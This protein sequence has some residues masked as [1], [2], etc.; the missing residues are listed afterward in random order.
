MRT[1][2]PS[3]SLANSASEKSPRFVVGII[4]DTDSLYFTSH[5]DIANVPGVVTHRVLTVKDARS[6]KI[7][8]DEGRSEI[9]IVG[10]DLLDLDSAV[11]DLFR[12]KLAAGFGLRGRKVVLYQ[13]WAGADFST[14]QVFQTQVV[15]NAPYERGTY[16]FKCA[17]IT[18]EQRKDIFDPKV[19]RLGTSIDAAATT[20]TVANAA[21]FQMIAHGA[22]FADAPSS[23]VGY[24]KI[25]KEIIRYEGITGGNTFTGC[26]RG[27][28]NTRAV[29]HT[30]D[31]N[32]PADRRTEV[33]EVIYL[34]LP[35][36][37]M[38]LAILTGQLY[39]Q[40]AS[41]PS[42]WHL[43]IAPEWVREADFTGIGSDLWNTAD[44]AASFVATFIELTKADGKR[45]LETE[46]YR[47]L[48][49]Y[50]I[51]YADGTYG[52]RRMNRVLADAPYVGVL[53]ETNTVSWS[54]LLLD[55]EAVA[56]D[57]RVEWN[58]VDGKPSRTT[59]LFDVNSINLHGTAKPV[60][61]QFKGL[62]GGRHTDS[63]VRARLDSQRDRY[64]HPPAVLGL[65]AMPHLNVLEVG[66][67]IRVR[68]PHI[69]DFAGTG[70]HINR[71]MEIQ[72]T[73]ID[74]RTGDVNLDL[75]G[76]TGLASTNVGDDD[77]TGAPDTVPLDDAF[78]DSQ[79]TELG[80]VVDLTQ[81]GDVWNVD[82]G[83]WPL[84]GHADATNAA[85]IYYHEG[86]LTLSA[87]AVLEITQ[88]VQLR[89]MG[90]LTI[91]GQ[92]DGIA[93]GHAGVADPTGYGTSATGTRGFGTT[94][95]MD[96]I[97]VKFFNIA[98]LK[99]T[100]TVGTMTQ[101][102]AFEVSII[103]GTP[104]T[105]QGLPAD[106]RGTSGGPG[107]KIVNTIPDKVMNSVGGTGGA[108]GAGL[109]IICRGLSFGGSGSINLSGGDSEPTEELDAF[110][111]H[112][113][114]GAG[115]PGCPGALMILLDGQDLSLPDLSGGNFLAVSGASGAPMANTMTA[116]SAKLASA[117][118]LSRT[119]STPGEGFLDP[120]TTHA[121]DMSS[122]AFRIQYLSAIAEPGQDAPAAV[123]APDNLAATGVP[124]G[125]LLTWDTVDMDQFDSIEAYAATTNDR[126]GAT[127]VWE[128]KATS[129]LHPLAPATT[130]Y[131][132]IH[133]RRADLF[134]EW[135]PAS[136]TGGVSATST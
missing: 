99:A 89:V 32:V 82:A 66:D 104:P 19:T 54:E 25:D 8:P 98:T 105:L 111:D 128:G 39:D 91:N 97:A 100:T 61:L 42:H 71:S 116:V 6:M 46:L 95:G 4:F 23:T 38:I 3:F 85:A 90:H 84:P 81:V 18:R 33:R 119:S 92:V 57:Y 16:R 67:I 124:N 106:L 52:I 12:G 69:R 108:G 2:S 7:F 93:A 24:I 117:W 41:L 120:A 80:T 113:L 56:N 5:A 94:R 129:Y 35:V 79:G 134:S 76:S 58:F 88:N 43:G 62:Y 86:D 125:I 20:I 26:T 72:G 136:A 29:P 17:D 30:V 36:P 48:G 65:Q 126:S 68:N 109:L 127:K 131:F 132:W 45:F 118:P 21:A 121:Q 28:L 73:R 101:V 40:A 51:V 130:R 70:D 47:L 10:F 63:T 87:D 55:M 31:L 50:P 110:W 102:P 27:V 60:S 11:T 64:A 22:S 9:G 78:Y 135:E 103:D 114:P 14:F 15:Q 44:D 123:P 74:L 107:G 77:G 1:H 34:E 115:A 13:G 83:T 122:A 49:C 96:G 37:K 75:F 59:R 53:D 133:G 112:L